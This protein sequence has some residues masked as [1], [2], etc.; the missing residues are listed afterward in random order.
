MS[1]PMN[2]A[3]KAHVRASRTSNLA[4]A[5]ALGSF[6]LGAYYYTATAVGRDDLDVALAKRE[7]ARAAAPP[8]APAP[9]PPA[10]RRKW[11]YFF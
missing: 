7:A 8:P 4:V 9:A 10:P 2:A 1:G 5:G 11:F 3:M 6:C